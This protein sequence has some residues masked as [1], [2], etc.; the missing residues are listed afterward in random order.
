MWAGF[1]D[2]FFQY[3]SHENERVREA[4]ST[5]VQYAREAKESALKRERG[6]AV[7]GLRERP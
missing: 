5:A 1:E 4:A 7:C 3:V 6:E 2:E